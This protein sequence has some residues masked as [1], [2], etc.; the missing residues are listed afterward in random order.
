M[1]TKIPATAD[2]TVGSMDPDRLDV[3]IGRV[4][5]IERDQDDL[6]D[7]RRDVIL[8]RLVSIEPECIGDLLEIAGRVIEVAR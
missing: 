3:L 7:L 5:D 8:D 1:C 6:D 4:V 2:I